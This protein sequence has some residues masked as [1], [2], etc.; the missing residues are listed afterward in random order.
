LRF[1]YVR[2]PEAN[3]LGG[4]EKLEHKL[5]KAREAVA[6]DEIPAQ[7][8]WVRWSKRARWSLAQAIGIARAAL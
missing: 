5:G 7:L 1:D 6:V 3:L 8:H 2:V 4:Q